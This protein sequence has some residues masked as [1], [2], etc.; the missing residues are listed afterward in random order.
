M[1]AKCINE[2]INSVLQGK[3]PEKIIDDFFNFDQVVELSHY[4]LIQLSKLE[5]KGLVTNKTLPLILQKI[6]QQYDNAW[7]WSQNEIDDFVT[8]IG[9]E[10]LD[11]LT[12]SLSD[13][14]KGKSKEEIIKGMEA[15]GA[16]EII[17]NDGRRAWIY[18]INGPGMAGEPT[19]FLAMVDEN[20]LKIP[21]NDEGLNLLSQSYREEI[22]KWQDHLSD[23]N[24]ASA[25]S[26]V[27]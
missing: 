7:E 16:D 6:K 4:V 21:L 20:G 15:M 22:V 8:G 23:E 2:D 12:E 14:L 26:W 17:L 9:A 1:R 18:E 10:P 25:I 3:D 11:D 19:T 24:E 13:V 27:I 5:E